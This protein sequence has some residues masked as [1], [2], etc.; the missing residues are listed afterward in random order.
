MGF[1]NK[2]DKFNLTG[3]F[4]G[5]HEIAFIGKEVRGRQEK[6]HMPLIFIS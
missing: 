2:L 5:F 6:F 3:A 1:P 4:N